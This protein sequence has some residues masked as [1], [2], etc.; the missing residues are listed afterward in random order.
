MRHGITNDNI[1]DI[2]GG[3]DTPL[4]DRGREQATVAGQKARAEGL[5]FDVI[6]CSP[7][8]RTQET[9]RLFAKAAGHSADKIELYDG[10]VE[11]NFGDLTGASFASFLKDGRTYKDI[12]TV[13][14][15]E[16]VEALQQRA[17]ETLTFLKQRPEHTIL[18]ISHAAFGRALRRAA[19]NI[20]YSDEYLEDM[21][22]DHINNATLIKII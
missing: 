2:F 10:L 4:T 21:P 3:P 5:H 16:T 9:A 17:A 6:L 11:R 15:V 12:D 1:H 18:V 7:Y 20:P 22:H 8:P 19:G 14:H 13:P